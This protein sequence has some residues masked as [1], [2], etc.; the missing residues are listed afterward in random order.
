MRPARVR[1]RVALAL[2]AMAGAAQA[3]APAELAPRAET[4]AVAPGAERAGPRLT[5]DQ[6]I[7]PVELEA[8]VDA[9]VQV[10]M[11]D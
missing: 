3:Q 9:T 2:L 8:F 5:P 6:S 7:P 4:S 1:M 10:A 11:D